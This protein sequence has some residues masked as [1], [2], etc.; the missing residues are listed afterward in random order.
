MAI[1]TLLW[2]G[3]DAPQ[4]GDRARREPRRAHGA[5]IGITDELRWK[6]DRAVLELTMDS[7]PADNA[8]ESS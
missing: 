1:R 3:P 7:G 4:D 8:C 2:R 5:Q 6:L